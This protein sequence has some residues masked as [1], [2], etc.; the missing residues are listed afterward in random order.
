MALKHHHSFT[1]EFKLKVI[2]KV[3]SD[4]NREAGCYFD[5]NINNFARIV[6]GLS[7]GADYLMII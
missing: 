5:V 7:S 6:C 3:E 4:G 2:E 1:A